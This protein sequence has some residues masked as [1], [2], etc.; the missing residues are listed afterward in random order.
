LGEGS[1]KFLIG[2]AVGAVGGFALGAVAAT[3]TARS[4]GSSVVMAVGT[5]ARFVGKTAARAADEFGSAIES[6]YT[7]VRGREAYLEHEISQLRNK[8]SDLEKRMD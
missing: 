7:K 6:G 8:I 4:A 1:A 5:S 2:A 3:P